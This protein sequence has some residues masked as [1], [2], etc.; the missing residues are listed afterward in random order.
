MATKRYGDRLTRTD[1]QLDRQSD[2]KTVR[3]IDKYAHKQINTCTQTHTHTHIYIHIYTHTQIER[4]RG[5][6]RRERASTPSR[7]HTG[8]HTRAHTH[9]NT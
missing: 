5:R 8:A 3:Q 1:G 4:E 6:K 2:S 9:I 7:M